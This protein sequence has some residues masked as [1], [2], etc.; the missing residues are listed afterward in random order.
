[1]NAD[2]DAY[3]ATFPPKI[4]ARLSQV[5]RTIQ[6][7]APAATE[8]ISYRIPAY[9]QNGMLVYFAGF[10]EHIGIYPPVRGS[11]TLAKAVA[12]FSGPKGNLKFP[13]AAPLP[14]TLV[15]RIVRHRVKQ[16]RAAAARKKKSAK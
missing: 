5:R 3:I 6:G 2:V 4:R 7:A 14:L 9:R 13:H 10:G 16:D 12:Q 8:V 15:A 1:M 11:A